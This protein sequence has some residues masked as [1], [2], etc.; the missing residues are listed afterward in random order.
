VRPPPALNHSRPINHAHVIIEL[1]AHIK[2]FAIRAQYGRARRMS[3]GD[4]ARD[5]PLLKINQA[6]LA[7][8]RGASDEQGSAIRGKRQIGS[9]QRQSDGGQDAGVRQNSSASYQA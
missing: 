8:R 4:A 9:W 7:H 2:R 6:N 5:F 1:I 3:G